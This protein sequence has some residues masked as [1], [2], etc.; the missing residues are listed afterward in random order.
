MP[1]YSINIQLAGVEEISIGGTLTIDSVNS[2]IINAGSYAN[3]TVTYVQNNSPTSSDVYYQINDQSFSV[4]ESNTLSITPDLSCS[5][6]GSTSIA[7]TLYGAPSFVLIDSTSGTLTIS[8]PSVNS[9]TEFDFY[10]ASTVSGVSSPVQK[11]VKLTVTN[12]SV[13]NCQKCSTSTV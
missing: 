4:V 12:C 8:A 6:S 11:L 9:D 1:T 7:Y 2:L 10:V 13:Q 5:A 3:Q